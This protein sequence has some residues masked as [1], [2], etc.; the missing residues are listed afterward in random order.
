MYLESAVFENFRNIDHHPFGFKQG[1]NILFGGN[2]QGK[3]SVI[4][5]IYLLPAERASGAQ[6]IKK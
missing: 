1:M 4:E 2:A 5:G 6:R 3:T